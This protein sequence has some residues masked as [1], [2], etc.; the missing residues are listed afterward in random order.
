MN[1]GLETEKKEKETAKKE[2]NPTFLSDAPLAIDQEKDF[3]FGHKSIAESLAYVVRTCPK[4]FTIGLFGKWGTGKTT[5]IH[6]LIHQLAK[7]NIL[8]AN[9]DAWKY[10]ED[11][12][13]RQFLITLDEELG[14]GRNY[15]KV[16]NQSLSEID[17][18]KGKFKF[19]KSMFLNRVGVATFAIALAALVLRIIAAHPNVLI[20]MSFSVSFDLIFNLGVAGYLI[21][22]ALS[23]FQRVSITITEPRT[24]SAEGFERIFV[25]EVLGDKKVRGKTLLIVVDNLDRCSDK[26]AVEM[27]ST[28]KTFLVKEREKASCVFLITCDDEAIKKHIR[29]IYSDD[30]KGNLYDANEF[31]RKF[32]NTFIRIPPFIDTE[33]QSY[34]QLL[35]GE[36]NVAEL[37]PSEVAHVIVSAFRENPRQIKQFINVLLAYFL[38]AKQ[39]EDEIP[40]LIPKGAVTGHVA[41][42]AKILAIQIRFSKIY[43]TIL[44][45]YLTFEDAEKINPNDK[46]YQ[47]FIR[48]TKPVP[49]VDIRPFLY[50]KMSEQEMA[51]PGYNELRAGLEEN[52]VEV[53]QKKFE[54]IKKKPEQVASLQ[55][56]LPDMLQ[57]YKNK[58]ISLLNIVS[59]SLEALHKVNLSLQGTYYNKVADLLADTGELKDDLAQFD[60]NLIFNEVLLKCPTLYR[61][62]II[63]KYCALFTTKPKDEKSRLAPEFIVGLFKQFLKHEAL[64]KG[65]IGLLKASISE[66]YFSDVDLLALLVNDK[67][68]LKKYLSEEAVTKYIETF[69]DADV[70]N[71]KLLDEKTKVLSGFQPISS[72]AIGKKI[73]QQYTSLLDS[74][75]QKPAREQR[76]TLLATM[77]AVL[78]IY[79]SV[80]ED[81]SNKPELL[82]LSSKILKGTAAL[83]SNWKQKQYYIP[84][85]LLL[86]EIEESNRA[87]LNSQ[88]QTFFANADLESMKGVLGSLPIKEREKAIELSNSQFNQRV[89]QD[90]NILTYMYDIASTETRT[91]WLVNIINSAHYTQILV[92]LEARKY[93]IDDS[94]RVLESLLNRAQGLNPPEKNKMYVATN[95]ITWKKDCTELKNIY[96]DQIKHL[97]VQ[98]SAVHQATGEDALKGAK[99]LTDPQRRDIVRSTIEWLDTLN[100]E[101]SL[102]QAAIRS[103]LANWDSIEKQEGIKSKFIEFLFYKLIINNNNVE[104]IKFGFEGLKKI[105]PPINPKDYKSHFEDIKSRIA[106]ELE[107]N[108]QIKE[109][110]ENGLKELTTSSK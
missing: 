53:I 99:M 45:N 107:G 44:E 7:N 8:I 98:A 40:P 2:K 1:I 109:I 76:K 23:F 69:S 36:T 51:I 83:S 61:A 27:L 6:W 70:D 17:P 41:F 55:Q 39:R 26:K 3:A 21:Q 11:S 90:Q 71:P 77:M 9:I 81:P 16:L 49:N 46:D 18:T 29:N 84:V 85:C 19:D 60:P 33:L 10:E 89:Q 102:Q 93:K 63:K 15:K 95:E 22:L 54:T 59:G 50:L 43:D 25:E 91:Q 48:S 66:Q 75:Q 72:I 88:T 73:L 24:D 108:T 67:E 68:K 52:N 13:R 28:I 38:L 56:L 82:A 94:R 65:K 57:K 12:L 105:K 5:I 34:T 97:L 31:I 96:A 64:M 110:L 32:F 87:N 62:S 58:R 30:E 4:P 106:R 104:A 47:N 37:L 100:A 79:K 78:R 74:E 92:F 35:L 103:I 86:A 42:L 14:L 101:N 20:P 80:I